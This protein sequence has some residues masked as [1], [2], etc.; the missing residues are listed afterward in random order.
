VGWWMA[1]MLRDNINDELY[2]YKRNVKRR[3]MIR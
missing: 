2:K 1:G 3:E